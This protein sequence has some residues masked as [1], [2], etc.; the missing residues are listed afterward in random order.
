[1]H[2]KTTVTWG[3]LLCSGNQVLRA[4]IP[5][6]ALGDVRAVY[7]DNAPPCEKPPVSNKTSVKH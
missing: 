2:F 7:I 4:T 5:A 3:K 1:M 6:N